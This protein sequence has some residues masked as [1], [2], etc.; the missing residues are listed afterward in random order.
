[1]VGKIKIEFDADE[2]IKKARELVKTLGKAQ[3]LIDELS[4][5]DIESLL[6]RVHSSED[7]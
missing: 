1:M 2:A 3:K 6:T 4:N 7:E 5:V